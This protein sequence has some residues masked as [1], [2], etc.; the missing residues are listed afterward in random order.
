MLLENAIHKMTMLPAQRIGLVDRGVIEPGACA[1]L[2]AF[3][4]NTVAD[5]AT[6][7]DPHQYPDGIPHVWVNG[8]QVLEDGEQTG[9]LPGRSV[10]PGG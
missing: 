6:F 10:R 8:V 4:G 2:V 3:D 9:A 1:D 7:D 5:R